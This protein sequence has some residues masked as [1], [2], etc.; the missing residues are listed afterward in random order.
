MIDGVYMGS[1]ERSPIFYHELAGDPVGEAMWCPVC[2]SVW[3]VAYIDGVDT[4]VHHVACE[5]HTS[6]EL[7]GKGHMGLCDY[8]GSFLFN[9]RDFDFDWTKMQFQELPPR[10]VL[11]REF[12][13]YCKRHNIG[14]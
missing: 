1:M 2:A 7:H 4:E 3:A 10:E 14:E 9:S 8:P 6:L 5:K 11:K 13:L 12:L